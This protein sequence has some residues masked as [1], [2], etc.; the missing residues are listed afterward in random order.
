MNGFFKTVF[1][2]IFPP[3]CAACREILP[4]YSDALLC[5]SCAEKWN[6]EAEAVCTL[7]RKKIS[8]CRCNHA[9][10]KE[11]VDMLVSVSAYTSSGSV[12]DL[13]VLSAKDRC[14]KKLF[15]FMAGKMVSAAYGA[16]PSLG[17][18]TVTFVPRSRSRKAE[19]GHDQSE[20]LAR[21]VAQKLDLPFAPMF[22]KKGSKQ[23]KKLTFSE[24]DKNAK[25]SYTLLDNVKEYV[26]GKSVLLCDDVVTT[27]ASV[28]AC[29]RLLR[30]AGASK[31]YVLSFAKTP[32]KNK[33]KYKKN[34]IED[35]NL[36]T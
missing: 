32:K 11:S 36:D 28:S 8:A 10:C 25:S 35:K 2:L 1:S 7:C 12:T 22:K 13:M 26:S 6:E 30:S 20:I 27:G 18:L 31:I 14:D 17:D 5:D 15:E 23:Q 3:R 24:R 16:L 29:A 9:R 19:V 34:K 21:L 33:I 4:Y